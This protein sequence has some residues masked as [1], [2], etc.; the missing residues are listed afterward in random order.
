VAGIMLDALSRW[1]TEGLSGAAPHTTATDPT[2]H[3]QS[4][5]LNGAAGRSHVTPTPD[6]DPGDSGL[7]RM[8]VASDEQ[9]RVVSALAGRAMPPGRAGSLH[10]HSR[11]TGR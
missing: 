5:G 8:R 3:G 6:P 9:Q 11:H 10:S 2:V 4:F 1:Q 7:S